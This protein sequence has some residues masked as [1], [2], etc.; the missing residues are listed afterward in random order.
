MNLYLVQHGEA[1]PK[2]EDPTC[3]LSDHGTE[4]VRRIAAWSAHAQLSIDQ[5]RHSGK[6]RAEQTAELFAEQLKPAC[7][8]VAISGISPMDIVLPIANAVDLEEQTIMIV[9]HLPFL[10]GLASQLVVGDPNKHL[11]RFRNAGIVCL[12]R[13][14]GKWLISWTVVPQLLG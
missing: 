6:K 1:K 3:P 7:G 12:S 4:L 10:S 14:E 2:T 8:V 9:G 5:I 11:L 13:D